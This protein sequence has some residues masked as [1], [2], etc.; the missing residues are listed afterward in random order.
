MDMS[1]IAAVN[2]LFHPEKAAKLNACTQS[3][4]ALGH[5]VP[6]PKVIGIGAIAFSGPAENFTQVQQPNGQRLETKPQC[7]LN[8]PRKVELRADNSE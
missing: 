4:A 3:K 5:R 7:K 8:Y 2:A 6:I 1:N